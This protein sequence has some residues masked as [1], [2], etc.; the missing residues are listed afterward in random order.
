MYARSFIFLLL[1]LASCSTSETMNFE[2]A[3]NEGIIIDYY[4]PNE[5][6]WDYSQV[7]IGDITQNFEFPLWTHFRLIQGLPFSRMGD[8]E[9]EIFFEVGQYVQKGDLLATRYFDDEYLEIERRR[10]LLAIEQFEH[11]FSVERARLRNNIQSAESNLYTRI[12][13]TELEIFLFNSSYTRADYNK[14]LEEIVLIEH[15]YAPFDAVVHYIDP[16]KNYIVLL[17]DSDIYFEI[18]APVGVIRHGDILTAH[19]YSGTLNFNIQAVSDPLATGETGIR[20]FRLIPTDKE[21]LIDIL[22]DFGHNIMDMLDIPFL[23][24]TVLPIAESAVI[25]PSQALRTENQNYFVQ[26]Y[27]NG[28]LHKRFINIGAR[29]GDRVQVL[30]GLEY[31]QKVVIMP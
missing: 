31:G 29:F 19:A 25:I 22:A 9:T 4:K 28:R 15:I 13:E 30:F 10:L 21:E 1:I 23:V 16:D 2:T 18:V 6:E 7:Y 5:F 27:E 26:I 8:Y 11:H 24:S 17:D 14:R 12:H 3:V 20:T